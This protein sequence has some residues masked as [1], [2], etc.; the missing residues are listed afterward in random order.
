MFH[1]CSLALQGCE[2]EKCQVELEYTGPCEDLTILVT[3]QSHLIYTV[4]D[5]QNNPKH[6]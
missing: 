2:V 6:A 4:E 1:V 3:I 5:T